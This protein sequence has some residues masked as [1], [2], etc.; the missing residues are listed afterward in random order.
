MNQISDLIIEP[1]SL[2]DP[3]KTGMNTE[4]INEFDIGAGASEDTHMAFF[5]PDAL[6][7]VIDDIMTIV[8][9]EAVA[10]V[11]GAIGTLSMGLITKNGIKDAS[12]AAGISDAAYFVDA[13]APAASAVPS[14]SVMGFESVTNGDYAWAA[15]A[16][17]EALRTVKGPAFVTVT[18]AAGTVDATGQLSVVLRFHVSSSDK[19]QMPDESVHGHGIP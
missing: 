11:S 16:T 4:R 2:R 17:T 10:P 9:G 18:N 19:Y 13:T 6:D 15:T 7:Y 3:F 5:L 1:H 8:D 12:P 14:D